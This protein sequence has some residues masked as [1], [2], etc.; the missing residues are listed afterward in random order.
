MN[1]AAP[2]ASFD[3]TVRGL[4]AGDF[5]RLAPLFEDDGDQPPAILQWFDEG[6][7]TCAPEALAEAFTCACFNGSEHVARHL[8]ARGVDPT[9]GQRTGMNAFH[10]AANR[11]Q[12]PLVQ[13]LLQHGAPLEATNSYGGTV[14]GCTLWSAF[15]EPRPRHLEIIAALVRGGADVARAGFPTGNPQIDAVLATSARK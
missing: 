11:G 3:E 12:L 8:L 9:G 5:T 15:H 7:F 4:L 2:P 1:D 6:R 14:L 10:C 13:L